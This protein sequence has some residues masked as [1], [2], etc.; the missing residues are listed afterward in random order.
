MGGN[1]PQ[2]PKHLP[3]DLRRAAAAL[4]VG[5]LQRLAQGKALASPELSAARL[6]PLRAPVGAVAGGRGAGRAASLSSLPTDTG[7]AAAGA[8]LGDV[9][10]DARS[11]RRK[12]DCL[13]GSALRPICGCRLEKA[14]SEKTC[15]TSGVVRRRGCALERAAAQ[16]CREAC[17]L[18]RLDDRRLEVVANGLLLCPVRR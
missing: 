2:A 18:D 9:M 10:S 6:P 13:P 16:V 14:R 3:G 7:D 15:S 5:F 4:E 12:R 17:D 1:R 11:K 8:P